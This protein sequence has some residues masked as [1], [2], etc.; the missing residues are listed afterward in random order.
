MPSNPDSLFAF[1]DVELAELYDSTFS[2]TNRYQAAKLRLKRWEIAIGFLLED[3]NLTVEEAQVLH[4]LVTSY[5]SYSE[6]TLENLQINLQLMRMSIIDSFTEYEKVELKPL[7]EKIE[8][9]SFPQWLAV[10]DACDRVGGGKYH[11]ENID[12]ELKRVGLVK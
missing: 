7:A 4:Y 9:W 8:G 12:Q 2:R 10:L 6:D 5:P 3:I 11:I 1:R